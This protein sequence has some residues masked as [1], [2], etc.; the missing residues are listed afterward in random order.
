MYLSLG[1]G[2]VFPT[3]ADTQKITQE[4]QDGMQELQDAQ[5]QSLISCLMQNKSAGTLTK[6]HQ[7]DE[8]RPLCKN[9]ER[10]FANITS[11]DWSSLS[12]STST[13]RSRATSL[14]ENALSVPAGM[15]TLPV[16]G[17]GSIR[18]GGIELQQSMPAT[19]GSGML[20]PFE[21]HPPIQAPDVDKLINHCR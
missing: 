13:S 16:R 21:A 18:R 19:V 17:S 6:R 3:T 8:R 7:C 10:H 11:C 15:S 9:C 5:S 20:D 2:N 14:P 12:P 1:L 4:I